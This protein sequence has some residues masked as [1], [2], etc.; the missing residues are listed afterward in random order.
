[1]H[2]LEKAAVWLSRFLCPMLS[3]SVALGSRAGGFSSGGA[4][5]RKL[6]EASCSWHALRLLLGCWL[7]FFE[8]KEEYLAQIFSEVSEYSC[9]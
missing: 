2:V 1:M 5:T 3:R 6:D 9:C 4:L 8:Q 7:G